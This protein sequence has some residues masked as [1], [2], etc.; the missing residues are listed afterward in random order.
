MGD[1]TFNDVI[2]RI[3]SSLAFK[4]PVRYGT[5]ANINLSGLAV[6]DGGDWTSALTEGDRILVKSQTN[7]VENGIYN[8]SVNGWQR[9]KD[10]DGPRDATKGTMVRITDGTSLDQ[11]YW[12]LTTAGQIVFGTTSLS[13]LQDN[14]VLGEGVLPDGV[15]TPESLSSEV[16]ALITS[17]LATE[18]SEYKGQWLTA[19][20]YISGDTFSNEGF[21]YLATE[22]H[23]SGTFATDLADGKIIKVSAMTLE[24]GANI[25]S[26]STLNVNVEGTM[27]N[28]TGTTAIT[29]FASLSTGISKLKILRFVSSLVL[30]HHSTNLDLGGTDITVTAGSVYAFFEYET[31]KYRMV[32]ASDAILPGRPLQSDM[33]CNDKVLS[34]AT[35]KDYGETTEVIEASGTTLSIDLQEGNV[36]EVTIDNTCQITLTNPPANG[37]TGSITL[38]MI[39]DA[40]GGREVTFTN[41]ITWSGGTP[42]FDEDPEA[43]NIV[44]LFTYNGGTTWYGFYV[45]PAFNVIEDMSL[46]QNG[47]IVLKYEALKLIVN[48]GKETVGANDGE[49]PV[50]TKPFTEAL[51]AAIAGANAINPDGDDLSGVGCDSLTLTT[52]R[53]FNEAQ[54]ERPVSWIAIGK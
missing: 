42:V 51:Y 5:V 10:F 30:T 21:V 11:S 18:G 47:H 32:C 45:F 24:P 50:F 2:D 52:M 31:G 27:H 33:D 37:V 3:S 46:A 29:A 43:I 8:A 13:F 25:A 15:V 6:Q 9:A 16:L 36:K 12:A 26:A 7:A 23:T 28:V 41:N 20:S 35:L 17:L 19:T 40:T 4:A 1:S 14:T 44:Q 38:I 48:W 34:K 53:V 39:Q 22:D 49:N 54:L